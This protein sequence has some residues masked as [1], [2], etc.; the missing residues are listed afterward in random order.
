MPSLSW[1]LALTFSVVSL[2]SASRLMILPVQV[3]QRPASLIRWGR[4]LCCLTEKKEDGGTGNH[5]NQKLP[6]LKFANSYFLKTLSIPDTILL[7]ARCG[8]WSPVSIIGCLSVCRLSA[9]CPI[10]LQHPELSSSLPYPGSLCTI[11]KGNKIKPK[12]GRSCLFVVLMG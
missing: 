1:I 7:W 9:W 12:M 6:N 4:P 11:R 3:S 10:G 8:L 2:C 5:W